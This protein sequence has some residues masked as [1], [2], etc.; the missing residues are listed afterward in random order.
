MD[1]FCL[2]IIFTSHS[3]VSAAEGWHF[4]TMGQHGFIFF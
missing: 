1:S 3:L 4:E 2:I